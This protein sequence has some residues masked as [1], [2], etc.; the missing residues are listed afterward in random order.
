MTDRSK[1]KSPKDAG[2]QLHF[3][4]K[5]MNTVLAHS[6]SNE[7]PC[8]VAFKL[9]ETTG[10][11]PEKIGM[12]VN[13]MDIRLSKC[14]LGLFGYKPEKK[15]VKKA[16]TDN[17]RLKNRI[18]DSLEGDRLPCKTVWEIA[19]EFHMNKMAVCAVCEGLNVKIKKCQLGAF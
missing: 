12:Y 11:P 9:S 16:F 13:N 1:E 2:G 15:I 8:A 6:E 10:V 17:T 14:Q 4:R 18:F 3:D 7:L 5:I 19:A